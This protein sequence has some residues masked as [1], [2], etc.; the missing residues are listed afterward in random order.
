MGVLVWV[1]H[2][3]PERL[4]ELVR[5]LL[6]DYPEL[7]VH[8]DARRL[9]EAEPGSTLVLIPRAED[10]DWLNI[11]RPLFA[12]RALRVVLFSS[13]ETSVVLAQRSVDFFDWISHRLECRPGPAPFAVTGLRRA[14]AV[15]A[16]GVVWKGGDLE[17]AFR[18]A[19]P[20]RK[21]RRVSAARPYEEMV[22]E[23]RAARGDWLA[24]TDVDGDFRLRRVRWALA[25]ARR[26]GR[27]ILVEPAVPSP[28]WWAVHGQ[29]ADFQTARERLERA[30]ARRPGRL[31]ALV[32]LEPEAIDLLSTLLEQGTPERTVE[33]EM[34]RGTDGG[35]AVGRLAVAR[36]LIPEKELVRGQAL[37][38]AMRAFSEDGKQ[39]RRL[40]ALEVEAVTQKVMRGESL[41]PEEASW[42]A[43]STTKTLPFSA[44]PEGLGRRADVVEVWLRHEP[45]NDEMWG[46]SSS[47]AL[48]IGDLAVAELWARRAAELAP[49]WLGILARVL[50]EEGR[51]GEAESIFRR[52]LASASGEEHGRVLHEL[53]G[54]LERQGR[55]M[56]AE[57]LLRQALASKEN[58][59]GTAHP[60]YAASL[61]ELATVLE[62]QGGYMEA[63]VLLRQALT[64]KENALG[65]VHP[66]YAASLH[67]LA[68]VLE[69]QGRYMEAEVLLRQALA[70]KEN[71]LGIAHPSYAAS[72]HELAGVLERQGR[73]MEAEVLLRQVLASKEKTLGTVH[74]SYTASLHELAGVLDRRGLYT[75]AEV[76]LRQVL[77]IEERALGTAHPGYAASLHALAVVLG[78]QGRYVEAEVLLRQVLATDRTALGTAHPSYAVSLR[79][80]ARVLERQGRYPEAEVLLH[81]VLS[82]E[83]N[84]LGATHPDL[85]ATLTLLGFTL[86]RQDRPKEAEPFLRRAVEIAAASWGTHHAETAQ[87]LHRLAQVQAALK[88]KEAVTTA[89]QAVEALLHSVGPDHPIT[90]QA[91]PELNRILEESSGNQS[92]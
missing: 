72:L 18:V 77:E 32:D 28:G 75:E 44:S 58:A 23:V 61:H 78:R 46:Q 51:W 90:R 45:V 24:W 89:R 40:R 64:N 60:S 26:R 80:L 56:E 15:R 13:R 39:A 70:S 17:A 54:V 50:L 57:V 74:P 33:K 16:P 43:A 7:E 12:A 19:R 85:C 3:C 86:A 35:A 84:A 8:S 2:A 47:Q 30:G 4:G 62:R 92:S 81:Q 88:E 68:G 27:S 71:A 31:A 79:E 29:V 34:A 36:Q 82:L 38:P 21:L 67:E 65:T 66:S 6:P 11:N 63:E 49:R 73:Y 76:L 91:L 10:A 37:A 69:R 20:R 59:L 52:L 53:A 48:D 41:D 55:Y 9:M 5:V 1:D 87:A 22:S 14:L 25:E 42:W 83:E